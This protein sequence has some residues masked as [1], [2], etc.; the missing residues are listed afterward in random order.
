MSRLLVSFSGGETSGYMLHWCKNNIVKNYDE[1][2]VVFANTGQENEETL[3]FVKKCGNHFGVEVVWLEAVVNHEKGKGTK[4]KIVSFESA[5]RFGRV[6]EDMI[7]VYGIPNK[8]YPHCTRELKLQP[9]TSYCRSIGWAKGSYDI[10]IGIRADE[11]D[12]MDYQAREKGI[13]YPLISK[14]PTTKP[15]VN[16]FWHNMPFRLVL[17]GY[18]GNCKWCWKKSLRKHFTLL[19]ERPEIYQ[20]PADMERKH[21][22]AGHNKDGSKRVFFRDFVSTIRLVELYEQAGDFVRADD[23]TQVSRQNDWIGFDIDMAGAC[24][25]SCEVEF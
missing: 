9:I 23:D 20:F 7:K 10:A 11:I 19:S 4:H 15:M 6:F 14:I 12:R 13:I 1:A 24:S 21:A 25:D 16:E 22:L 5:D 3:R 18:E 2:R 17:K 8:A